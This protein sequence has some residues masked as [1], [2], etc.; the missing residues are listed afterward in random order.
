MHGK[1]YFSNGD[2]WTLLADR[3]DLVARLRLATHCF[4]GSAWAVKNLLLRSN[5]KSIFTSVFVPRKFCRSILRLIWLTPAQP[6]FSSLAIAFQHFAYAIVERTTT[7]TEPLLRQKMLVPGR[8][9]NG[10][11][12]HFLRLFAPKQTRIQDERL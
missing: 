9:C 4:A 8:R 1:D 10:G 12:H 5:L 7:R 3:Q 2:F 11:R 6:P